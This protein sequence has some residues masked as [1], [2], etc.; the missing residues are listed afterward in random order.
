MFPVSE[1]TAR[2]SL[3]AALEDKRPEYFC[4]RQPVLRSRSGI[5]GPGS[6]SR[7]RERRENDVI[8][9]AVAAT[10]AERTGSFGRSDLVILALFSQGR[11]PWIRSGWESGIEE[12]R[13]HGHSPHLIIPVHLVEREEKLCSNCSKGGTI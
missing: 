1:I 11:E 10:S 4:Q 12:C 5:A 3:T 13:Q 6:G 7:Y 9:L 8:S 2:R